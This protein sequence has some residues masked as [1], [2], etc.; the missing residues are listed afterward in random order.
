MAELLVKM[1]SFYRF[2]LLIGRFGIDGPMLCHIV[3]V[4]QYDLDLDP[5]VPGPAC[6]SG[7]AGDRP[8]LSI[9]NPG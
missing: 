6:F 4:R 7:I 1:I 9:P 3:I 2:G 5:P 8:V